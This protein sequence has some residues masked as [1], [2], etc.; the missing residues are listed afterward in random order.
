VRILVNGNPVD[1]LTPRL[2]NSLVLARTQETVTGAVMTPAE[3]TE[4]YVGQTRRRF[5]LLGAIALVLMLAIAVVGI[6]ADPIDGGVVALGVVI[7][8]GALLL[9]MV[10]MLRR[11]VRGW[12]ARLAH[13][14]QGLTPAGTA[15][16]LDAAG[17]TIGAQSFGWPSLR[18]EQIELT[19]GNLPSDDTSEDV[20][21]IERLALGA[22][23]RILVLD[24]AMLKNGPLLVDNAWRRLHRN[25]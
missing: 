6:V 22:G 12:N 14:G 16:G 4:A 7:V 13:R 8:G 10:L 9:F 19:S 11:R 25:L 15:I 1:A 20:S 17:V 2:E 21:V 23:D 18:I 3:A 24:R 5:T